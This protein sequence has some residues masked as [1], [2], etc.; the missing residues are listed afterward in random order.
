MPFKQ[1]MHKMKIFVF[2][3]TVADMPTLLPFCGSLLEKRDISGSPGPEL[4]LIKYFSSLCNVS[5]STFS[6]NCGFVVRL[7][8]YK[9]GRLT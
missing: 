5:L 2:E 7:M 6:N 1:S 4:I 3:L 8:T 9:Y